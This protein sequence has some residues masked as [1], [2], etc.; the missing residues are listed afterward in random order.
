VKEIKAKQLK[1]KKTKKL[2]FLTPEDILRVQEQIKRDQM[3]KK[4]YIKNN[5]ALCLFT[6]L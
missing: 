2:D 6:F 3:K 5:G 4:K 1:N